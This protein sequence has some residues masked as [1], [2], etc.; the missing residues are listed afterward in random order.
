MKYSNTTL[1][2]CKVKALATFNK[3]NKLTQK[4]YFVDANLQ[5]Q[6]SDINFLKH[7]TAGDVLARSAI[8]LLHISAKLTCNI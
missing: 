4:H 8:L 2:C 5:Y 3:I 6:Q 1:T 7:C